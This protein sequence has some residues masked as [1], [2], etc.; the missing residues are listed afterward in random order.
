[1]P[2]EYVVS[3]LGPGPYRLTMLNSEEDETV[4]ESDDIDE[5][6]E[7]LLSRHHMQVWDRADFSVRF[8]PA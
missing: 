5:I 8:E 2:K 6:L 1:M 3:V 4:I 7:A